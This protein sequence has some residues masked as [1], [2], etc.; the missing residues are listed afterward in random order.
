MSIDVDSVIS[1]EYSNRQED[2]VILLIIKS[3]MIHGRCGYINRIF[4]CMDNRM[5]IKRY[6][7]QLLHKHVTGNGVF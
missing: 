2:Q 7:G 5:C 6:P 1:A 3:N 4:T